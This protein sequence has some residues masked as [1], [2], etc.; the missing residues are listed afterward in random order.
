MWTGLRR[1]GPDYSANDF[2]TLPDGKRILISQMR[3]FC[4]GE[5]NNF[6]SIEHCVDYSRDR[7]CLSD[8]ACYQSYEASLCEIAVCSARDAKVPN[9]PYTR[10]GRGSWYVSADRS[11]RLVCYAGT[12]VVFQT[13]F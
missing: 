10:C 8:F 11:E 1:P 9:L 2:V 12:T 6:R 4:P 3:Q 5:P 7:S 13:L